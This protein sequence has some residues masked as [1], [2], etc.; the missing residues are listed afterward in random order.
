M[1]IGPDA[2]NSS[3]RQERFCIGLP[4]P[5]RTPAAVSKGASET[6]VEAVLNPKRPSRYSPFVPFYRLEDR[7]NAGI[8]AVWQQVL[9]GP[10]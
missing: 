3:Q 9:F 5:R 1:A 4:N 7:V 6:S 10:D 8:R 2:T